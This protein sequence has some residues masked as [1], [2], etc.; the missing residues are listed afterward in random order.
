MMCLVD[1]LCRGASQR[2]IDRQSRHLQ[3]AKLKSVLV[4]TVS[5]MADLSMCPQDTPLISHSQ[6]MTCLQQADGCAGW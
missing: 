2:R 6:Q 4:D 1:N 5:M 3:S